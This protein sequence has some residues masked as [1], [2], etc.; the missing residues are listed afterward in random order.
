MNG[1]WVVVKDEHNLAVLPPTPLTDR[2]KLQLSSALPEPLRATLWPVP[3]HML[4]ASD[5]RSFDR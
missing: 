3:D 2:L 4:A 1:E 5:G